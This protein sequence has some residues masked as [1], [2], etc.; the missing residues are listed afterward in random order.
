MLARV[1]RLAGKLLSGRVGQLSGRVGQLSGRVK[2]LSAEN[3]LRTR[4]LTAQ[5]TFLQRLVSLSPEES[6]AASERILLF[7]RLLLP[8]SIDDFQ[9]KRLG[10]TGDAGYVLVDDLDGISGVLSLGI[11]SNNDIDYFFAESLG[12]SVFAYD[13]TVAK[14]PKHHPL[15]HFRPVGVGSGPKML[16]LGEII[17]REDLGRAALLMC[18]VEGSEFDKSFFEGTDFSVFKQISIELHGLHELLHEDSDGPVFGLLR[19]VALTHQAVHVH[20]NNYDALSHFAG[21]PVPQTLE[22]T[23]VRKR[24]YSFGQVIQNFPRSFD[25]PNSSLLPDPHWKF[26]NSLNS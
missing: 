10:P 6:K 23:L 21:L 11:G 22:V 13:H 25:S 16:G 17:G 1:I 24:D 7:W 12:K 2:N 9:L 4:I 15:I 8:R 26:P 3:F 20:V 18:D 19:T 5:M 14:L